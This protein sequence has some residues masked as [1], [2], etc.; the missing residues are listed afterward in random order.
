MLAVDG[1]PVLDAEL[2]STPLGSQL[3]LWANGVE[4]VTFKD[5]EA[6]TK[7]PH[8]FVV[9]QFGSP[10]DDI[11]KEVIEPVGRAAGFDTLRADDM[12]G[13]GMILADIVRAIRESTVVVAEVS[14]TNPN[15]YYEIGYAHAA[16]T[17][18]I[19]LVRRGEALPFDISGFRCIL[20]DDTIGGKRHVEAELRNHL[21]AITSASSSLL[22]IA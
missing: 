3:G 13:P 19:L 15:V 10:Y 12:H 9:M 17:P 16:G 5:F 18:T 14:A 6:A 1:T 22:P 4:R 11:F 20:Y 2:P 7:K 8:L 21:A